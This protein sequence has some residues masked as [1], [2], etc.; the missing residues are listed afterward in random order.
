MV[1]TDRFESQKQANH[2]RGYSGKVWKSSFIEAMKCFS[3]EVQK[4]PC[5]GLWQVSNL[6]FWVHNEKLPAYTIRVAMRFLYV[7]V[8]VSLKVEEDWDD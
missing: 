8:C 1:F 2:H 5:S 3:T 6:R 7:C 4:M